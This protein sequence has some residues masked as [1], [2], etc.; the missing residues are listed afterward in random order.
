M[1]INLSKFLSLTLVTLTPAVPVSAAD[2]MTI[3]KEA[4]PAVVLIETYFDDEP[5][6]LG[7]G[8]VV[9]SD[10]VVVTNYH[11]IDYADEATVTLTDG[12]SYDVKGVFAFDEARDIAVLEIAGKNLPAL[13]L[14]DSDSIEVGDQVVAIGNPQG[15]DNTVSDGIVSALRDLEEEGCFIQITAPI[16][17]GSSGG[18]L[19]D[20]DGRVVG[21]TTASYYSGQNLNFAVPVNDVKPLLEFRESKTLA[22]I[23]ELK[24][25][26][27][28]GMYGYDEVM[29]GWFSLNMGDLDEAEAH[30]RKVADKEPSN[31]EAFTGLGYVYLEKTEYAKARGYFEEVVKLA[32]DD[33]DGYQGIGVSFIEEGTYDKAVDML[34]RAYEIDPYDDYTVSA[35]GEAYEGAGRYNDAIRLYQEMIESYPSEPG[36]YYWMGNCQ[37]ANSDW[38]GAMG[39]FEKLLVVYPDALQAHIGLGYANLGQDKTGTAVSEFE[40]ALIL[41][42]ELSDEEILDALKG[43]GE[44]RLKMGHHKKAQEAFREM[45]IIDPDSPDAHYGLGRA[46]VAGGDYDEAMKEA[47]ILN[48]LDKKLSRLLVEQ[49]EADK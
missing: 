8:F 48:D 41:R 44:A 37:I 2:V 38:E 21:V 15:L 30:F 10:G 22:E 11:V 20:M 26:E 1:E 45:I 19:L 3:A 36:P 4:G 17:Q 6:G 43:L 9:S 32:P 39:S 46:C 18:A 14:A 34:E 23:S 35:L 49:I 28:Y 33:P 12:R 13:E 31:V 27:E 7:S 5:L 29:M 42:S 16:S 25:G 24:A 47:E 40:K